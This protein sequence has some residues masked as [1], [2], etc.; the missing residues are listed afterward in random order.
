MLLCLGVAVLT[1]GEGDINSQVLPDPC[2]RQA[3]KVLVAWAQSSEKTC[4]GWVLETKTQNVTTSC[5]H[6][7][8]HIHIQASAFAKTP[9]KVSENGDVITIYHSLLWGAPIFCSSLLITV[10]AWMH[11]IYDQKHQREGWAL[12]R[13]KLFKFKKGMSLGWENSDDCYSKSGILRISPGAPG[14]LM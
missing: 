13:G 1:W 9:A 6:P 12:L 5:P 7:H 3:K 14:H 2:T 8:P 4:T 10:G 11:G